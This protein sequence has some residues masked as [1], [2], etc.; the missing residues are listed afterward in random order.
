MSNTLSFEVKKM[1][2]SHKR[3]QA[4]RRIVRTMAMVII[5]C[6]TYALIL[7][8]IT[9]R[10]D[11]ICGM[12]EHIH[13]DGCYE[14]VLADTLICTLQEE[15]GHTHG[16]DC[17]S[18]TEELICTLQETEGHTHESDCWIQTETLT[19]NLT[20]DLA[21]HT[22]TENCYPLET[23][24]DADK[25]FR[26]G[27]SE[28]IH[29]DGCKDCTIV[30]HIHEAKCIL[31]KV[32]MSADLETKSQWEEMASELELTGSWPRDL[33]ILAQSQLG[34]SES[35]LNVVLSGEELYGYSRYADWYGTAYQ[36]WNSL[37]IAF[38]LHYAGISEDDIP[39]HSNA[40]RWY[41]ELEKKDLLQDDQPQPGSIIFWEDDEDEIFTAIV[42]QVEKESKKA[43]KMTYRVIAGDVNGRVDHQVVMG[44]QI[45]AVCDLEKAQ[46]RSQGIEADTPEPE[47]YTAHTENYTVT[48]TCPADLVLPEGA[49]L[50]VTEY[51]KDSETYIR[52]CQEAGYELE[53]L[54]NIGFFLSDEELDLDGDF[55]VAVTSKKGDDLSEDIT[56]FADSGT[57]RLT[58][59][60]DDEVVSFTS[61]G[62]SDF[63]GGNARAVSNSYSFTTVNPDQLQTGVN[64]VMFTVKNNQIIFLN[65]NGNEL[66]AIT[67]GN[68]N[69]ATNIGGQW[70]L[71]AAQMGNTNSANFSWQVIYSNNNRYLVCQ[72][73]N[74][75]LTLMN[76]WGNLSGNGSAVFLTRSGNGATV[77]T[78]ADN[79]SYHLRFEDG[80]R[81]SWYND[82]G[83]QATYADTIYFAAIGTGQ[84]SGGGSGGNYPH[85]VHT[86]E[87]NI[88]RLRFYNICENDNAGVKA[89]AGCVFE[90]K[91]T[92]GYTTTVTS[93][94]DSEVDLP[95][96]IPD[97]SYTITEISVPEGY[98][99]DIEYQ[100]SFVIKNSALASTDTIGTFINH[101]IER[102]VT[103]KTAEVEDYTNRT[104]KVTLTARSNMRLYELEPIDVLF[105]LD[106]SNSMLFPAVL[107]ATGK[108][109]TLSLS[110]NNNSANMDALNLDKSRMHYIIADPTGSSTVWAVWHDGTAWMCQDASYYAKAKHSNEPGY[111]DDN[112]TVI[113]PGNLSYADQKK[114]EPEGTRSNG[115]ALG[116]DLT[117]SSL[118]TYIDSASN[119]SRSFMVYTTDDEYNRLHYLEESLANIIYQLADVN[120][121]NRV[122]ITRFTKI[123]DQTKDCF[124]PLELSP[125]NADYLVNQVTSI[126]TSGGTRQDLA[127]EHVYKEHLSDEGEH[128]DKGVD[129]T[130]T[131][132]VT[133]GAPVGTSSEPVGSP[134]DNATTSGFGSNGVS[135]YGRI[136]GFAGQVRTKSNLMTVGLGMENVE[137]G[138]QVLEEIASSNDFYCAME[139]AQELLTFVQKLLFESFKPKDYIE[140]YGDI[141]D[142]I[143][144]SFYPIAWVN[145]GSGASTG[146]QVLYSDSSRDWVLLEAGDWIT[147][148]G[149]L[150]TAGASDA[151][152]HLLQKEDGTYYVQWTHQQLSNT[153]WKGVIYVKAKEDFIG[154]NGIDTNKSDATVTVEIDGQT[155]VK[156]MQTPTVNVRLLDLNEFRTGVT[157]YLGDRINGEG[158]APIDSIRGFYEGTRFTK[159]I[160]DGGAVLNKVTAAEGDGL[161]NDVFYLRYALGR[162]LTEEE[163][164]YLINGDT[165]R[166]PY[167][168]DNDS[169]HGDVGY[170]TISLTKEGWGSAYEQHEA[171]DACQPGGQPAT[172]NCDEPAECY[173]LNIIYTAYRLNEAGRPAVNVRNGERGPGTEVGT[174]S[175]IP[176][177]LGTVD[178]ENIHEVHVI[179]G[180]I[181]IFKVFAQ[182][183]TCETDRTFAFTLHRL[184]DGEDTGKDVTK[185]ITIPA[186]Q[187]QGTASI[188][189]DGL[190][191]GTYAVSEGAD[192]EYAVKQIQVLGETNC[193]SVPGIGGSATEL[194]FTMGSDVL[195]RNVIGYAAEQAP[196]TSYI[197]PPDG[198]YGVAC[199]TN[200][201]KAYE[202]E[203]PVK[204][205]WADGTSAHRDHPVYLAL[206]LNGSPVLDT[207]G[208]A[209][210]LMLG[211]E[212]GWKGSFTVPLL[213]ENDVLSNYNY[214]VRELSK[215]K[216]EPAPGWH[217]AILESTGQTIYYE[218][219]LEQGELLHLSDTAYWIRYDVAEDGTMTV[220]N[221]PGVYLPKTG[222]AGVTGLYTI[223][224]LLTMAAVMVYI[225]IY[226]YRR[227]KEGR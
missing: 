227:R 143:S 174:G 44:S 84:G 163:W 184:E 177:G 204:K 100:R 122:G 53:W 169:S 59:S 159:L 7:P 196:Y 95:A 66:A 124:G 60:A 210:V 137:G 73:N 69:N 87:V 206:Y 107:D 153:D 54:L 201:M 226:G 142:D 158:S 37:F 28:H 193:Y 161:E 99:R 147:L 43:D 14:T 133:D 39:W 181:E 187:S 212:N 103:G 150:T 136:K 224:G 167:V 9:M 214:S 148:A 94:D 207:D 56:H 40:E 149:K 12:E 62:F 13:G 8:A 200:G 75:R 168:Y 58:G 91:G 141:Y 20:C 220:T 199:F 80:W 26:C 178:R 186:G 70:S 15:E 21:E 191:R 118:G 132:L 180:R 172:E 188:V 79:R 216:T 41:E 19:A 25:G 17:R 120:D 38:C 182:N 128:F 30:E 105:V 175:T 64:Y 101:N 92:N 61:D 49:R 192:E 223:G 77:G 85:A 219:A 18:E 129:H 108:T 96:D 119:D 221:S 156:S 65:T 46:L 78:Y 116:K 81:A 16:D 47:T 36:D 98:I 34:Y 121:K 194:V 11:A 74:N 183:V 48:V 55:D 125:N 106:Q 144:E 32:D 42:E 115:G 145:R 6:T 113:F 198:V 109:V 111:Q 151:A 68:V 1:S 35:S 3:R 72:N 189:F 123:V 164:T 203:I 127:L 130:Y 170:F 104:Y 155:T 5:F 2:K 152:G 146:N 4:W 31:E 24:D 179:S 114:S 213:D 22:H 140:I 208:N 23:E 10:S 197:L 202:A 166:F 76:G 110:G 154:G 135:I 102:I 63:G 205:L 173:T 190:G 112:E 171:I 67:T 176:T 126:K 45:I 90:I 157:V 71:T 52:R 218:K 57:E 89:L 162:E 50:Q 138:K 88:N 139:D 215:I 185:Y 211:S 195:D 51:A 33:L 222:G 225:W 86:G 217:T 165:L 209:R 29:H 117:G 131:L 160:S 134:N 82:Y 97:G 93:G 27:Y 83:Q